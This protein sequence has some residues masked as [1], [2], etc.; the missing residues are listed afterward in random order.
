MLEVLRHMCFGALFLKW[1]AV[2]LYTANTKVPVNR[3]PG[4]RIQHAC[5]L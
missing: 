5:G 4:E 3:I 2:L 1:V